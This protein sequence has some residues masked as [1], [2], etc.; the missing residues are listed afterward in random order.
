MPYG[1]V[2][3][4]PGEILIFTC[5]TQSRLLWV[6]QFE[7]TSLSTVEHAYLLG[8]P[9][10]RTMTQDRNRIQFTFSLTTSNMTSSLL[11]SSMRVTA[12]H[13]LLNG[14]IVKCEGTGSVTPNAVIHM[15]GIE[16]VYRV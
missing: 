10:G 5:Q 7:D 13:T 1:E 4:C 8:D 12:N 14:A 9:Q 3:A 11:E 16:T 2:H 6:I 15:R